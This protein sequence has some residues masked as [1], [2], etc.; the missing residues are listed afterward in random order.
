[1]VVMNLD[2]IGLDFA[3]HFAKRRVNW[4]SGPIYPLVPVP[5]CTRQLQR[6]YTIVLNKRHVVSENHCHVTVDAMCQENNID[7]FK[8]VET[9]VF[10]Y[11]K[12]I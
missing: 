9:N 8:E 4:V 3:G 2:N 10:P 1:M 7:L 11:T 12:F 6:S 5:L